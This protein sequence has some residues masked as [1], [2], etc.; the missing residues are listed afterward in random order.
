MEKTFEQLVAE[1][2]YAIWEV[3]EKYGMYNTPEINWIEAERK[4]RTKQVDD[5]LGTSLVYNRI[6]DLT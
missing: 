5:M 6:K 4:I 3:K 1:E 2:A